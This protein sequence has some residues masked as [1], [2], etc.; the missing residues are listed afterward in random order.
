MLA[1][2]GREDL[3]TV[4][5]EQFMTDTAAHADVVLPAYPARAPRRHLLL[6]PPLPDLERA[7]DESPRQAKPNTE[8]FS[9]IAQ[10]SRVHRACFADTDEELVAQ[11]L[12]GFEED[13]LREHG[14][15]KIDLGQGPVPHAEGGLEPNR[16][17]SPCAPATSRRRR[18]R[19]PISPSAS[20]SP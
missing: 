12:S 7:R 8:T 2:L 18:S 16:A 20:H 11:L 13:G 15:Q 9:L 6:G 17:R 5:L 14:W 10:R 3:F 19:T 1:G 4:V